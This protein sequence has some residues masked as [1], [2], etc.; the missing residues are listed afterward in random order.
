MMWCG[1]KNE[2]VLV[3]TTEGSIYRSRDRGSNWKRLRSLMEKH[4]AV[5]ADEEQDVSKMLKYLGW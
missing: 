5:V 1:P 2:V 3:H 4:G